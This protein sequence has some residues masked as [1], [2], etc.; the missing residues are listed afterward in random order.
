MG[1]E[2][3]VEEGPSETDRQTE[4]GRQK[5]HGR[6]PCNKASP[7]TTNM[8]IAQTDVAWH[9]HTH[10]HT[11]TH[12]H[13]SKLCACHGVLWRTII[14]GVRDTDIEADAWF[15]FF[16]VSAVQLSEIQSQPCY[17]LHWTGLKVTLGW[18][19]AAG[20]RWPITVFL[21]A[22]KNYYHRRDVNRHYQKPFNHREIAEWAALYRD[23]RAWSLLFFHK[24]ACLQKISRLQA[25]YQTSPNRTSQFCNSLNYSWIPA[26]RRFA[27]KDMNN[28]SI[29]D[30]DVSV[31]IISRH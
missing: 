18:L 5:W 1:W 25:T 28:P 23:L 10:T 29:F 30:Y 9:T 22:F 3:C 16:S 15:H 12:R 13:T 17:L 4:R 6:L 26:L 27:Y 19:F 31:A 11:H 20:M 8:L 2:G 21:S 24:K 14:T 7:A